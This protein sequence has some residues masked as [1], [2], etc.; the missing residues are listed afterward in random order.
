MVDADV[1]LPGVVEK[2]KIL[3]LTAPEAVELG[4]A[5]GLADSKEALYAAKEW[6]PASTTTAK[7]NSSERL[8]RFVTNP[9]VA[10][11][12]LALGFLGLIAEFLVPG[13]G[14]P[15][16]VG[17][18]A[19]TAYFG[20]HM[21][22]GLAG[23][24][25][26]FAFIAGVVLLAIEIFVPGFGV[27]GAAGIAAIGGSIFLAAQ[28]F[29]QAVRSLGISLLVAVVGIF[30]VVKYVGPRGLWQ[31]LL[32]SDQL[33]TEHGYVSQSPPVELVGSRGVASSP[34]RPAGTVR[35]EGEPYSVVTE[36][37]FI[38]KGE[39]VEVVEIQGARI[40]V[41]SVED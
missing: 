15:G 16:I 10:P 28:S 29:E 5:D 7:E 32:L 25:A 40:V 12:L 34:L 2:G 36:G 38:E 37:G 20:G 30:V 17:I 22:A 27:F 4:F 26:I 33:A 9:S 13:F 31:R 21:I 14:V 24:P 6:E 23:W 3:T 19:F 39:T 8:A 1:E 41:R 11:I 35:I 18:A